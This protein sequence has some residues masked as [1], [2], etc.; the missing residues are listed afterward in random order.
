MWRVAA[1]LF[2]PV[3]LDLKE[4][5]QLKETQTPFSFP[6]FNEVSFPF[7]FLWPRKKMEYEMERVFT[8]PPPQ[9]ISLP[10]SLIFLLFYNSESRSNLEKRSCEWNGYRSKCILS[11]VISMG[12]EKKEWRRGKRWKIRFSR[13]LVVIYKRKELFTLLEIPFFGDNFFPV[14]VPGEREKK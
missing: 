10:L 3:L 11:D 12:S 14:V 2:N 4:E 7:L 8:F 1:I 13:S 5:I 9:S 6:T